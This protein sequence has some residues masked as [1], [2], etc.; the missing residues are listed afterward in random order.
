MKTLKDV[1]GLYKTLA[2]TYMVTG[3]WKPAYKTG[4]LY[5]QV[6]DYNDA[7]Q[8][9]Q[10]DNGVYKLVLDYA[11]PSAYYGR[12][13]EN[14]TYKMTARP[15]AQYAANS[16]AL[17]AAIDEFM[18]TQVSSTVEDLGTKLSVSLGK[19]GKGN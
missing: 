3:P 12:Y 15:F 19:F 11:P 13:V 4:N 2:Q 18:Q 5:K 14:G 8:M 9:I 10:Q 17:K 7:Q 6:G 1:A 16:D